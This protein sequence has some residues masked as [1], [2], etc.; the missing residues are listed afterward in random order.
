MR[1]A[2]F[3]DRDGV[4]NQSVV[5]EGKPY[6]PANLAELTILPG[7]KASLDALSKAGYLLIVITNQPDVA[8]GTTSQK[9]VEEIHAYLKAQ[10]PISEVF[11]CYHLDEHGCDCRKPEPGALLSAAKMHQID[12]TNSYMIGDRWRDIEAGERAGCQ[13]IFIDYGYHEKQPTSMDF[14]VHSLM[15]ASM[16][17]LGRDKHVKTNPGLK[18]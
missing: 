1:C 3:L 9:T 4:I 14:S 7:V 12:L 2:V 8:R 18:G 16:I 13:T 11:V 17:I 15:D 10:L 5:V 6:P